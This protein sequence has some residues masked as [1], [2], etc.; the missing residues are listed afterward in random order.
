[1]KYID[2]YFV[3]PAASASTAAYG[4]YTLTPGAHQSDRQSFE[5]KVIAV[6]LN[7]DRFEIR[8]FR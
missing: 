1:M 5:S 6:R 7:P 2:H 4:I 8:I 3:H